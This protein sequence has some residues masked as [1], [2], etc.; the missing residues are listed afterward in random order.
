MIFF[1][2]ILYNKKSH[3][4]IWMKE[5]MEEDDDCG[6]IIKFYIS[7]ICKNNKLFTLCS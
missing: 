6:Y 7:V 5:K 2:I 3:G 1:V 4:F